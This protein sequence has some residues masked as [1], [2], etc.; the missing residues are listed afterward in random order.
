MD[1]RMVMY[2]FCERITL[3]VVIRQDKNRKWSYQESYTIGIHI[4]IDFF[5]YIGDEPPDTE[6][7]IGHYILPI[8]PNRANVQKVV[9]KQTVF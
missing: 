2:N 1:A 3:H 6:E 7:M 5:R 8:R 4:C 9:P